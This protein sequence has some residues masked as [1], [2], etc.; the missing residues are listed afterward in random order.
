MSQESTLSIVIPAYN[1][2]ANIGRCLDAIA[3][4]T[5]KPDQVIVVDNNSGDQTAQLARQYDF[6]TVVTEINQGIAY[7]HTTGFNF[8]Q[9]TLIARIDAETILPPDWAQRVIKHFESHQA[10]ALVGSG[11]FYNLHVPA[12]SRATITSSIFLARLLL[13]HFPLWGPNMVLTRDAWQ[14]IRLDPHPQSDIFDDLEYSLLLDQKQLGISWLPSLI[15]GAQLRNCNTLVDLWTYNSR[16]PQTLRLHGNWRW[17]IAYI[18]L[19]FTLPFQ[20]MLIKL[21]RKNPN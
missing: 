14:S 10:D 9:S 15:V 8:A 20:F 12:I 4:Q 2:A 1:E 11:Y 19:A 18:C 7:A 17:I 6:V 5:T 13:G 3:Q 21:L 16:W